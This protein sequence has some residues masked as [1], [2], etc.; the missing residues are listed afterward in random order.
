[1]ELTV[2]NVSRA[3]KDMYNKEK[4]E[5]LPTPNLIIGEVSPIL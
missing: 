3:I 5:N 4:A 1:M 2:P